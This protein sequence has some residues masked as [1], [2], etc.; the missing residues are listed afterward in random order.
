MSYYGKDKNDNV[1][2]HKFINECLLDE[3]KKIFHAVVSRPHE[4]DVKYKHKYFN[5]FKGL[6]VSLL[7]VHKNYE[8]IQPVLNHIKMVLCKNDEIFGTGFH[9]I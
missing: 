4:L 5:L 6:W 2:K 1:V 9:N 3:N 7:P 8:L